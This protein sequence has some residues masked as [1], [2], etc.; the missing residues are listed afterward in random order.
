MQQ[1]FDSLEGLDQQE[2]ETARS[3][4]TET[5]LAHDDLILLRNLIQPL[6]Q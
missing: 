1:P 2:S 5:Q 4:I 3:E 6:H